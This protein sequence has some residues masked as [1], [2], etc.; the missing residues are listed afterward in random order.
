MKTERI[1]LLS[2]AGLSLAK[3]NSNSE[4]G[5][6]PSERVKIQLD[7]ELVTIT[8]RLA[9]KP[10]SDSFCFHFD[11]PEIKLPTKRSILAITARIFDL[12]G[13]LSAVVIRCKILL[14]EIWLLGLG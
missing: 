12:L 10:A 9:W 5:L 3:W 11:R 6:D 14:Q 1:G 8:L 13:L 2:K 4:S 7:I